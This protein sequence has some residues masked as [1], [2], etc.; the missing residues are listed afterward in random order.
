VGIASVTHKEFLNVTVI[1]YARHF[2]NYGEKIGELS[3][4]NY[5]KEE[6]IE[7]R[8]EEPKINFKKNNNTPDQVKQTEN[9]EVNENINKKMEN[10][11]VDEDDMDLPEGVAKIERHE[12]IV[13]EGNI[14]KKIIKIK[15]FKEDG[16][17][18][19]EIKKENLK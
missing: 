2:F 18:E 9:K 16:T 10:N 4:E 17:I 3:D 5:E 15:K 1:C 8:K 13:T 19:V 7:K 12:K 11:H 6:K 14:Q